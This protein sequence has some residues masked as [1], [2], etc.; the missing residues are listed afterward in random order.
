LIS[1]TVTVGVIV[2]SLF[3]KLFI[4]GSDVDMLK[5]RA[6]RFGEVTSAKLGKVCDSSDPV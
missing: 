1:N 3:C 4:Q 6:E 5:K 2:V